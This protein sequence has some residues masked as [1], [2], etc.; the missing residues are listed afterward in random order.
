[1][2]HAITLATIVEYWQLSIFSI[3]SGDALSSIRLIS[4]AEFKEL[5]RLLNQSF[6]VGPS[7]VFKGRFG[8][9]TEFGDV[10]DVMIS[11]LQSKYPPEQYAEKASSLELTEKERMT[12]R[13]EILAELDNMAHQ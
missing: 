4:R 8:S 6:Q 2:S 10:T 11:S 9:E 1:M 7:E 3:G 13:D 12:W 5:R